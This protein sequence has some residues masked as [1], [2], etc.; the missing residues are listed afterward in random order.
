MR[1]KIITSTFVQK[2]IYTH[3]VDSLPRRSTEFTDLPEAPVHT[4][5]QLYSF[6]EKKKHL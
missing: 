3:K 4:S 1:A 5:M 6:N 2:Q